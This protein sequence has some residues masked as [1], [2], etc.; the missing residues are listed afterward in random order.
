[1]MDKALTAPYP[2]VTEE[3]STAALITLHRLRPQ[4]L[5][6]AARYRE[7]AELVDFINLDQKSS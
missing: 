3:D 5:W 2:A 7:A 4:A 6:V 1:M